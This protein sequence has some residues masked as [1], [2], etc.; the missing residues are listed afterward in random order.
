MNSTLNLDEIPITDEICG[1]IVYQ[2]EDHNYLFMCSVCCDE[3]FMDFS[4]FSQHY[5]KHHVVSSTMIMLRSKTGENPKSEPIITT[6]I[7]QASDSSPDESNISID[8]EEYMQFVTL[9]DILNVSE[10]LPPIIFNLDEVENT[11]NNKNNNCNNK[12]SQQSETT[13]SNNDA[14]MLPVAPPPPNED[15]TFDIEEFI[16]FNDGEM[17]TDSIQT[18][19][20]RVDDTYTCT[21]CEKVYKSKKALWD[22]SIYHNLQ[23]KCDHCDKR[24]AKKLLLQRHTRIHT[25]DRPYKCDMCDKSFT[26][27]E[28]LT[29][30]RRTHTGEKPFPCDY[31]TKSFP[32]A[33]ARSVH[34]QRHLKICQFQCELC[35]KGFVTKLALDVHLFTHKKKGFPCDHCGKLFD[36]IWTK[37]SHE[38]VHIQDKNHVCEVCGEKFLRRHTLVQHLKIHQDERGYECSF[39]GC[40]KKFK[41]ISTYYI[42]RS[43]H[44][45][46]KKATTTT[47]SSIKKPMGYDCEE[48]GQNFTKKVLFN[49]HKKIHSSEQKYRN[50]DDITD[51]LTDF[52]CVDVYT[53]NY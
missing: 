43:T 44:L 6:N 20:V 29:V 1:E 45:K 50:E 4:G 13:S 11:L 47:A 17:T 46:K 52:Q 39:D 7:I 5:E 9:D 33:S 18:I 21:V 16:K 40:G 42:H 49:Q 30:H 26:T 24:F 34:H 10:N 48:C 15:D 41:Q 14:I 12:N 23:F 51:Y 38:T 3:T 53:N 27:N 22:H 2:K 19:P 37:K 28:S 36:N 35:T 25:Q 32:T 8:E 31:C